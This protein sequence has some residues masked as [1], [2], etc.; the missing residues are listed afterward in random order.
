M[1]GVLGED[2]ST[3]D[4]KSSRTLSM[5]R[6]PRDSAMYLRACAI[7]RSGH[8]DLWFGLGVED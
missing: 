7:V 5:Y 2:S 8:K 6:G 3:M 1:R 4:L